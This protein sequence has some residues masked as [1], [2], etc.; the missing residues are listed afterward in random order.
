MADADYWDERSISSRPSKPLTLSERSR[1]I[2][3]FYKYRGLLLLCERSPKAL[4]ERLQ[5]YNLRQCSGIKAIMGL[6]G[7]FTM[8][9]CRNRS[10]H[11]HAFGLDDSRDPKDILDLVNAR[12]KFLWDSTS[13]EI[14][15]RFKRYA[16]R[17]SCPISC[18][19]LDYR[20][21]DMRNIFIYDGLKAS[22]WYESSDDEK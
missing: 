5:T 14:R 4:H 13:A 16:A 11:D 7:T 18:T 2:N 8:I 20:D 1:F 19:L 6:T 21:R 22:S 17:R 9:H 3:F 12:W 10:A 15:K